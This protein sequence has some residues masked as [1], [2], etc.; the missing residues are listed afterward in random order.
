MDITSLQNPRVKH[1]VKLRDDKTRNEDG[2][3]IVEGYDEIQLARAA[4]HTPQTIL[5]GPELASRSLTD[6][7]VETLTVSRAV[8]EKIRIVKTPMGGW[9]SFRF[10]THLLMI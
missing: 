10:P 2:L 8:F 9:R 4:G 3:M 7:F 5:F 6:S 1:I